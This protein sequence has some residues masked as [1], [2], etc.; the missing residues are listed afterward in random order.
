[1][2]NISRKLF[3]IIAFIAALHMTGNLPVYAGVDGTVKDYLEQSDERNEE[4]QPAAEQNT[5]SNP[6][7]ATGVT[8]MD[9]MKMIFALV[10]VIALIYFLLKFINQRS[11]SFQQTKLIHNLGGTALGGN[12][13]VQLV[14]VGE[15]ILILGVGEDIQLLKEID[16]SEEKAEILHYYEDKSQGLQQQKDLLT[17]WLGKKSG[18]SSDKPKEEQSFQALLKSQIDDVRKGRK[19]ML[20]DLNSREKDNNE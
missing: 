9:Y 4:E 7:P 12:R 13:S 16:G 1:M 19:K 15:R 6:Q 14:K 11:K 18:I 8:A 17:Q 3:F 20:K 2:R 5:T 10:F